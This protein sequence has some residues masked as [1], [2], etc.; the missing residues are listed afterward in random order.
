MYRFISGKHNY[1]LYWLGY[2]KCEEVPSKA[3]IYE[4][5]L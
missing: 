4:T 1:K 2:G 5:L 3:H